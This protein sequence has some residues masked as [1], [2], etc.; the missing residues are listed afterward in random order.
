MPRL[1]KPRHHGPTTL[2]RFRQSQYSL[3]R[4]PPSWCAVLRWNKSTIYSH[5][6]L[7]DEPCHGATSLFTPSRPPISS[8][9][10]FCCIESSRLCET[11]LYRPHRRASLE[12]V[13]LL[14]PDAAQSD[15]PCHGSPD[16]ALSVRPPQLPH[17]GTHLSDVSTLI[18]PS[19]TRA[20][21]PRCCYVR[22]LD[23]LMLPSTR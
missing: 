18:P 22:S 12:H 19:Q 3:H 4:R 10:A 2:A 8:R 9:A 20:D 21:K 11:K 7:T 13:T 6:Y 16:H 14:Q 23:C 5:L 1:S 17:H 15:S